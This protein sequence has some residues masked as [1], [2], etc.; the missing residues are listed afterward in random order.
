LIALAESVTEVFPQIIV[1]LTSRTDTKITFVVVVHQKH[2]FLGWGP[3]RTPFFQDFASWLKSDFE[4]KAHG[5][6]ISS[7]MT[8]LLLIREVLAT[9]FTGK[10][11]D[12][13]SGIMFQYLK[14]MQMLPKYEDD[15]D[16]ENLFEF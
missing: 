5:L 10:L 13:I 12:N 8:T 9:E 6:D 16:D 14:S 4:L 3:E 2:D 7:T 15:E 11:S 1:N